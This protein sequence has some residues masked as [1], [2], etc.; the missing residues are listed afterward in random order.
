MPVLIWFAASPL[1]APHSSPDG[2]TGRLR[3]AAAA[4]QAPAMARLRQLEA[5]GQARAIRPLWIV[6]AVAFEAPSAVIVAAASWPAVTRVTWD[7]TYTRLPEPPAAQIALAADGGLSVTAN[8]SVTKAPLLWSLGITGSGVVIASLDTGVDYANLDLAPRWRGGINSWF[9]PYGQCAL[10]CDAAGPGFTGHGS[11]TVGLM[12]GSAYTTTALGMAPG[13][14]WIAARIFNAQGQASESA[15]HQA[16]Q[17]V[18]D[19]DGD[20]GTDDAPDIVNASW[21]LVN[22]GGCDLTFAPDLQALVWAGIVPVFAAGNSG[23]SANTALSPA[24]NPDAVAVGAVDEAGQVAASSSRGP[25]SCG[26]GTTRLFPDLAAP[27]VDVLTTDG[28]LA[29]SPPRYTRVSGTSFAAPHVAGGLALLISACP[30]LSL[31]E[32]RVA[33]TYTAQPLPGPGAPANNDTGAGQ[34]DVWAAYQALGAGA[35]V[36]T[37]PTATPTAVPTLAPSAT[38]IPTAAPTSTP[39]PTQVLAT[40]GLTL[41]LSLIERAAP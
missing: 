19:P 30:Q 13:A 33:L 27:G 9:D 3:A 28:V 21:N 35:C 2:V 8:I 5:Q 32:L 22:P 37:L 18:L 36:S 24:N 6:N 34:L 12:V 16:F 17:W 20:P 14:Q 10:P 15:I 29:G 23:P 26:T 7:T 40:V 39:T 25:T 11:Q 38:L 4:Q 31:P 1:E 41:Y